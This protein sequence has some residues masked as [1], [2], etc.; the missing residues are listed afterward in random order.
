MSV[1]FVV[2]VSL[3]SFTGEIK[4]SSFIYFNTP[5]GSQNIQYTIYATINSDKIHTE[6]VVG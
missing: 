5:Q 3:L 2:D 6:T 1:C 4:I